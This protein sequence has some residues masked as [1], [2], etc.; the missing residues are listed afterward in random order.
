M[1]DASICDF[2]GTP[3]KQ[4]ELGAVADV[5][6]IKTGDIKQGNICAAC[7]PE[8]WRRELFSEHHVER[9][10]CKHDETEEAELRTGARVIR[11][12]DC[13]KVFQLL[14]EAGQDD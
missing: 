3:K 14:E 1:S 13:E 5:Q 4:G 10:L 7:C 2:C 8:S 12:A 9:L 11:C 6:V